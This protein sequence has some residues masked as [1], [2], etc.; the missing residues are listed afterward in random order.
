M[1]F[2]GRFVAF[3]R[4]SQQMVFASNNAGDPNMHCH[5]SLVT[6]TLRCHRNR[7]WNSIPTQQHGRY[8]SSSCPPNSHVIA[9]A[10]RDDGIVVV[11]LNRPPA[12][13]LTLE[14]MSTLR[15]TIIALEAD[16]SVRALVLTASNPTIF[17][18][19]L[20]LEELLNPEVDRLGHFWDSFQGLSAAL[21]ATPLATACAMEG[22]APGGG[23]VL[24]L[25][26]ENRVMSTGR[27]GLNELAL[28][29]PPPW[30]ICDLLSRV[31]GE[32]VGEEMVQE[33]R[34]VTPSEALELGLIDVVAPA[35]RAVETAVQCLQPKLRLQD[36]ARA[37]VKKQRREVFARQMRDR[38]A[39]DRSWFVNTITSEHM[40]RTVATYL[41]S[42]GKR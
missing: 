21:F 37:V 13:T 23:C 41:E 18:A 16:E 11:S 9:D 31:V 24:A 28:G 5:R 15:D 26:C 7:K 35:G 3:R 10:S 2:V 27:I 38:L 42:L 14:C 8:F 32:R 25:T 34:L 12:N 1:F 40:Q 30:W 39:E 22:H 20:A 29:L 17:S 4:L 6:L 36:H 19:G 33:A